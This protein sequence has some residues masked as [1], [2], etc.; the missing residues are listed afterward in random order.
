M[1]GILTDKSDVEEGQIKLRE[2]LLVDSIILLNMT[3]RLLTE[4]QKFLSKWKPGGLTNEVC[5]DILSSCNL[6]AYC[7]F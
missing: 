7:V 5:F 1:G 6:N 3:G 2:C 4:S